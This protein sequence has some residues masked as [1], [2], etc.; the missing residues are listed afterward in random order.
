M[1]SYKIAGIDVH[2]NMLAV[3]VTDASIEGE[4]PFQRRKFGTLGSDLKELA[5]WLAARQVREVVMESTAQYWK[6]VWRQLER[7]CQL[8]LAQA[9]SNRARKGRKD[10]FRDAERLARRHLSGELI[11]SFVP[12]PEQR[13]WRTLTRSKHQLT[14]D[15][16]RLNNQLEALLE[17]ARIKLATCVTDLLGVSSRRI[18]EQLAQGET[19][20]ARLAAL[21]DPRL[22][23]PA[24]ELSDALSAASEM[25]ALH[26]QILRL[27]LERLD[28]IERQMAVLDRNMAAALQLHHNAVERLA[29][30]PGLGADSAHQI[31][32][33]IGPKAATFHSPQELASWVGVCPGREESAEV[34]HSDQSPRGNRMMRRVL[35][36]AANSARKTKGSIFQALYQRWLPRLGHNKTIWA[37]AHR[38][39]RVVWII[40]HR[41]EQYI[42]FGNSRDPKS[43]QKRTARLVSKLRSLGY[44]V[45]PPIAKPE[46][47]G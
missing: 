10:D 4:L 20:P 47:A 14:R 38:L 33:E 5:A 30:V 35:N 29:T 19:D 39:C 13:L 26:R 37:I 44:Q 2:K 27:F 7:Q 45:T 15:R 32:A 17:D 12:D 21:A 46:V 3:V 36:Q 6:P 23:A 41:G 25:S 40:L 28:L 8:H 24:E 18:M 11:L 34:S 1:E 31:I 9:H 16:V 22:N 42:E 43:A